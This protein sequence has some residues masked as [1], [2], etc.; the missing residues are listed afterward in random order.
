MP[1]ELGEV[2]PK[3]ER[4]E[5]PRE[6]Y[7]LNP[8]PDFLMRIHSLNNGFD[9]SAWLADF[10]GSSRFEYHHN[11]PNIYDPVKFGKTHPEYYPMLR[12]K[13]FIPAVKVS[14]WPRC[15]CTSDRD[16]ACRQTLGRTPPKAGSSREP[17]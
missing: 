12:G 14:G 9:G 11:T 7:V 6:L 13:R 1:G 8:G 17:P 15:G 10:S 2:V 16:S 4:I 3:M 5:I